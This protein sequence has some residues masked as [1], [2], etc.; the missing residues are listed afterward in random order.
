MRWQVRFDDIADH[1]DVDA[2]VLVHQDVAKAPNLRPRDLR[3]HA[4]TSSGR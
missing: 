2:E 1:L 4:V 3:L